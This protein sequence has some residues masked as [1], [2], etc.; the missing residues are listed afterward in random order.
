MKISLI[1]ET[2]DNIRIYT[3][4]LQPEWNIIQKVLPS[5]ILKRIKFTLAPKSSQDGNSVILLNNSYM[6]F[7]EVFNILT[8]LFYYMYKVSHEY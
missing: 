7:D 2:S 4:Y 6:N 3:P 1:R 8:D 5:N